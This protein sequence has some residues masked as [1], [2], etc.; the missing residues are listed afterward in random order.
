LYKENTMPS[1]REAIEALADGLR[2]RRAADGSAYECGLQNQAQSVARLLS[3]ILSAHPEPS[4]EELREK[5]KA[6]I[7]PL[8]VDYGAD[9]GDQTNEDMANEY[10]DRI[11]ALLHEDLADAALPLMPTSKRTV[12][13]NDSA[14]TDSALYGSPSEEPLREETIQAIVEVPDRLGGQD[15]YAYIEGMKRM[16]FIVRQRLLSLSRAPS[17]PEEP[18]RKACKALIEY[19]ES[20]D[21]AD[22]C[23]ENDDLYWK[24]VRLARAALSRESAPAKEGSIIGWCSECGSPAPNH[25]MGCSQLLAPA[26]GAEPKCICIR[27][28]IGGG[29]IHLR[30]CP[31]HGDKANP[32]KWASE[33]PT[34]Q[35]VTMTQPKIDFVLDLSQAEADRLG[36]PMRHRCAI[37]PG[38]HNMTA[39]CFGIKEIEE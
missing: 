33:S 20:M 4:R 31:I 39:N 38:W 8:V 19:E 10:T 17:K 3:A 1:I 18:L 26:K 24:A 37:D 13:L 12:V 35:S 34:P 29:F 28:N 7:M 15:R 32:G 16:A 2:N 36:P 14:L 5:V 11:L 23:G 21:G 22:G 27:A 30:G 25:N 9:M 6:A